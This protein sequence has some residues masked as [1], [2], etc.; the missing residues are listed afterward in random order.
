ME[1]E[2]KERKVDIKKFGE[3]LKQR[4]PEQVR[5]SIDA[6]HYAADTPEMLKL[7]YRAEV[8]RRGRVFRDDGATNQHIAS[9]A[10]WLTGGSKR[11][12]LFIYGDP[13]NGKTTLARAAGTLIAMLYENESR[14]EERKGVISVSALELADIA[15]SDDRARFQQLKNTELLHIDDVGTEPTNV[16][17]WGNELSPLVEI[18]YARY[19]KQLYTVI[20]SNLY[21]EDILKRYG[22]RIED[23]LKEMFDFLA[24]ENKS[25]R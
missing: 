6:R 9:F 18:L 8:E 3:L 22:I 25:Y 1:Q 17:V 20:T 24:F 11:P 15:K 2:Q 19:D 13:G 21:K 12:G 10:K 23:R 7:C 5:F 4:K 14:Y 16:K